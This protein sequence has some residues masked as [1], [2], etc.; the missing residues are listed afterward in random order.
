MRWLCRLGLHRYRYHETLI[1]LGGLY[2]VRCKRCDKERL[3]GLN[4]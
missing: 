4:G 3:T 2:A 1:G